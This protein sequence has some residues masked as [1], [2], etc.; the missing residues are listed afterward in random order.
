[1]MDKDVLHVDR[2]GKTLVHPIAALILALAIII[3]FGSPRKYASWAFIIISCFIAQAQRIH[4]IGLDFTFL[5]ILACLGI[6]RVFVRDEVKGFKFN[7]VDYAV[8]AFTLARC[9]FSLVHKTQTVVVGGESQGGSMAV[10][11]ETVDFW[12][13]YFFI[14]C[15]I[16]D[17]DDLKAMM[18]GF[19][20]I[21]IPVAMSFIYEHKAQ[22]NIFG[23]F[24]TSG[25]VTVTRSREGVLRCMGAYSHPI[26]AGCFWAVQMP[27]MGAY[28]KQKGHIKIFPLI[29]IAAASIVILSTG[30]SS[31]IAATGVA[32]MGG[33]LFIFRKRMRLIRWSVFLGL[34]TLQL[35]MA[36]GAAHILARVNVVGGS[37]G[38]YRFKLIDQFVS[39]WREWVVA[40]S[41]KGTSTWDVPMYDIV[42]YYV[43]LGF[44]GGILLLFLIF[45]VFNRAFKQAGKSMESAG[46]DI[47]GQL[48]GWA[49]G[50]SVF[51]H[52][53]Q[54]MVVS[55]YGQIQM[56]WYFSLA[57]VSVT[58]GVMAN[59]GYGF[60]VMFGRP[61]DPLAR[62]AARPPGYP[63][64]PQNPQP[65]RVQG[66]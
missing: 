46:S 15:T 49:C 48:I 2:F 50:V 5:R 36:R 7:Q 33:C 26:L 16:R 25:E 27:L 30:S 58:A 53:I 23:I 44:A 28:I 29:G 4:V 51:V 61:A 47:E 20:T 22:V 1:M 64:Y 54:F 57:L 18:Y 45:W 21:A 10:Y 11:G 31:G 3:L 43:N 40:G 39:H 6:V 62:L 8:I 35:V 52:L 9:L 19:M 37:T 55:Y 63:R 13:M 59:R 12:G 17:F 56:T 24:R 65:V 60:P 41:T 38:Y 34:V 66:R 14:R 32:F 42:N